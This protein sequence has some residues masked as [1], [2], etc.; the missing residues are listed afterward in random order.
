MYLLKYLIFY[1]LQLHPCYFHQFRILQAPFSDFCS[2]QFFENGSHELH[3]NVQFSEFQCN[4]KATSL[5]PD[6]VLSGSSVHGSESDQDESSSICAQPDDTRETLDPMGIGPGS[7][8]GI[9]GKHDIVASSVQ[10]SVH[11][12]RHASSEDIKSWKDKGFTR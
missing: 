11:P 10:K 2:S 6:C 9:D 1:E 7:S 4:A 8:S 12:G 5:K 3:E